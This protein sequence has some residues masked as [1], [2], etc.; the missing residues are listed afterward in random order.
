MFCLVG[1]SSFPLLS[2]D[3]SFVRIFGDRFD[4]PV[5]AVQLQYFF[6][7]VGHR[8]KDAFFFQ[9]RY[10]YTSFCVRRILF[11]GFRVGTYEVVRSM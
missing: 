7:R 4:V 5:S 2:A 8:K 6:V 10:I 1:R 3:P 11:V 9:H